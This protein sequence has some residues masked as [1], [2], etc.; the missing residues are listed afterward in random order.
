MQCNTN[1]SLYNLDS[2]NC[3]RALLQKYRSFTGADKCAAQNPPCRRTKT[4]CVLDIHTGTCIH[5]SGSDFVSHGGLPYK[6]SPIPSLAIQAQENGEDKKVFT[7]ESEASSNVQPDPVEYNIIRP[8]VA[9]SARH[10]KTA[11]MD[12]H[13]VSDAEDKVGSHAE[14]IPN[15]RYHRH[16]HK[17]EA[18]SHKHHSR[19]NNG[20]NT[21]RKPTHKHSRHLKKG[22]SHKSHHA[23]PKFK[24]TDL[25]SNSEEEKFLAHL[26]SLVH[27]FVSHHGHM[28]R[29][30]DTSETTGN[31]HQAKPLSPKPKK[32]RR[33]H[34]RKGGNRRKA[35]KPE[36]QQSHQCEPEMDGE[37][38]PLTK[39]LAQD[40]KHHKI[41]SHKRHHRRTPT[42]KEHAG[43]SH[44][45]TGAKVKRAK[46]YRSK[47]EAVTEADGTILLSSGKW[48]SLN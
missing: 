7:K 48:P 31:K 20:R 22:H 14:E 39:K 12:R 26:E 37:D 34:K 47:R 1:K 17:T 2:A 9:R 28:S 16:Q 46:K 19:D 41:S 23:T 21:K 40:R 45:E 15:R 35:S 24:P 3:M 44:Q 4:T 29:E 13:N 18:T 8:R 25:E 38:V 36:T 30:S 5:A 11:N 6:P 43:G 10:Y 33:H 27:S 42:G 32:H